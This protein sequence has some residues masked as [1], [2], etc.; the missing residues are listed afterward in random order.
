[1]PY[2]ESIANYFNYIHNSNKIKAKLK[3]GKKF[4]KPKITKV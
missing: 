3:E 2:V 1:M 4:I